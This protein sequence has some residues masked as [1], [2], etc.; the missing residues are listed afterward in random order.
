MQTMPQLT[1]QI[2]ARLL[3]RNQVIEPS[4]ESLSPRRLADIHDVRA[5]NPVLPDEFRVLDAPAPRVGA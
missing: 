5:L 3:E 4:L 1:T 2:E